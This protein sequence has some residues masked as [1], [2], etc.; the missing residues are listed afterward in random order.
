MRVLSGG[1]NGLQPWDFETALSEG[2]SRPRSVRRRSCYWSQLPVMGPGFVKLSHVVW[3]IP[4]TRPPSERVARTIT[5]AI[6][7]TSSPYSTAD[8]PSSSRDEGRVNAKTENRFISL[9][10]S[11]GF[12]GARPRHGGRGRCGPRPTIDYWLQVDW[13]LVLAPVMPVQV[14]WNVFFTRPPSANTASTM[15][16]AI[17]ATSRPYSTADAPSSLRRFGLRL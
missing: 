1:W 7:A 12:G 3:N 16:A 11:L 9:L 8:A 13:M 4:L 10:L 2:Q 15:T 17:R 14:E 6:R 5:A